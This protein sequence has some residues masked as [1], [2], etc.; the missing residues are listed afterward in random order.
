[1]RRTSA[2]AVSVAGSAEYHGNREHDEID[3]IMRQDD[4]VGGAVGRHQGQHA[5]DRGIGRRK[6]PGRLGPAQHPPGQ[7]EIAQQRRIAR[8]RVR[9]REG[10]W[11]SRTAGGAPVPRSVDRGLRPE[12]PQR[13]SARP[14]PAPRRRR[15]SVSVIRPMVS[16]PAIGDGEKPH[17]LRGIDINRRDRRRRRRAARRW[18]QPQRRQ[19]N[20]LTP[21]LGAA[22]RDQ[23][24]GDDQQRAERAEPHRHIRRQ[25]LEIG[26][27]EGN[28][29]AARRRRG[30]RCCG[31]PRP[32]TGCGRARPA[33]SAQVA[34]PAS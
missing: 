25:R 31:F 32:A 5:L 14:A 10:A 21:R 28:D 29:A 24:G 1:M 16:T 15:A 8:R 7:Q 11:R 34:K 20:A 6:P 3:G 2:S 33:D 4:D 18:R 23:H 27:D 12:T 17:D 30:G 19:R 26:D 22:A 9:L 13:N